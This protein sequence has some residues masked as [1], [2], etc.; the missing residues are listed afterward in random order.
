MDWIIKITGSMLIT[1]F[2]GSIGLIFWKIISGFIEKCGYWKLSYRILRSVVLMHIVPVV[3]IG[4]LWVNE[5]MGIWHGVLFWTTR[6]ILDIV[7]IIIGI[8]VIGA[9][10]VSMVYMHEAWNL[11]KKLCHKFEC[12]K[13]VQEIYKQVCEEMKIPLGKV[14]LFQS[15]YVHVP[16]ITGGIR[17]KIIL[18]VGEYSEKQIYTALVHELTHYR[19]KDIWLKYLVMIITIIHFYNPFVWILNKIVCR[20]SEYYCDGTAC[21]YAESVKTY[22]MVILNMA[23]KAGQ[24]ST[25][26]TLHLSENKNELIR[27]VN[28]MKKVRM[29][30]RSKKIIV[31]VCTVCMMMYTT[32]VFGASDLIGEQY[33][34]WYFDTDV[35]V[36]EELMAIPEMEEYFETGTDSD[37]KIEEGELSHV[38]KSMNTF[39]WTIGTKVMKKTSSFYIKSGQ[40]I[41][42]TVQIRPTDKNVNVGLID[43]GG[44]KQYVTGNN[45]IIHQFEVKTAGNY[46]VFVENKNSVSVTAEGSYTK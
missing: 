18:P 21:E 27:R 42:I 35:A 19:N 37:I 23:E 31:I 43:S 36:K 9:G 32:T 40:I 6:K 2:M 17:T 20:Q 3:F 45:Y 10:S 12:E 22:F 33:G 8:W 26:F 5:H 13:Q 29:K 24:L 11:H 46:S 16:Q 1:S 30:K 25:Y 39:E 14:E 28:Y 34:K 15:Y 38:G 41:S 44:N 7:Y 4:M